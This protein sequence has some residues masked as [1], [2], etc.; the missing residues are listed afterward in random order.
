MKKIRLFPFVLLAIIAL[1]IGITGAF[2]SYLF[3]SYESESV[4]EAL[5]VKYLKVS[6]GKGLMAEDDIA[7]LLDRYAGTLPKEV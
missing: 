3:L 6:L 4:F 2:S 1:A 7:R 5:P